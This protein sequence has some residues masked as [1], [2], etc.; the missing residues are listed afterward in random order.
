MPTF[1]LEFNA[2]PARLIA[3]A[4]RFVVR[5][6]SL[7]NLWTNFSLVRSYQLCCEGAVVGSLTLFRESRRRGGR[8]SVLVR[9]QIVTAPSTLTYCR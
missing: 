7:G 1:L 2:V 6:F 5:A 9:R 8:R 4:G 3:N